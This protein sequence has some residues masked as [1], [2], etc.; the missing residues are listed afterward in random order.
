MK[1]VL[2]LLCRRWLIRI[3]AR[4]YKWA[5]LE[6]SILGVRRVRVRKLTLQREGT[7]LSDALCGFS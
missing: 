4:V 3:R 2:D 6:R 7:S 1:L 5:S